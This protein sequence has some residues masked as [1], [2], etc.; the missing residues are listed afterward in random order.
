M[1]DY[2]EQPQYYPSPQQQGYVRLDSKDPNFNQWFLDCKED[3]ENMKNY[4]QG[5]MRDKNGN[6][7]QPEDFEKRRLMKDEGIHWA[8]QLM[9]NFLGKTFLFTNWDREE[10]NFEMRKVA[11]V[12]WRGLSYQY[13]EFGLSKI[14]AYVIGNQI[15]AQIH[16]MLL[17]AR[18]EGIRKYLGTTQQISEI[19]QKNAQENRGILSNIMGLFNRQRAG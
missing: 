4:W 17:S 1:D 16:S 8:A 2:Q 14:N 3:I 11:R 15:F 9:E 12:I 19:N 10:M 6:W 5:F 18:G 13:K 7:F